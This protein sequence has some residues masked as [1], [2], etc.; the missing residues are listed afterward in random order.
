[1]LEN[2]LDKL[3]NLLDVLK[4]TGSGRHLQ[5]SRFFLL[6]QDIKKVKAQELNFVEIR[7]Q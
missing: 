7:P 5:K 1:M 4:Y 3:N 2:L 6:E